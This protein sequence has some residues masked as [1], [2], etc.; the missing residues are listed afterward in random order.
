MLI[1]WLGEIITIKTWLWEGFLFLQP[2][3][4]PTENKESIISRLKLVNN[5]QIQNEIATFE[6]DLM[7][8]SCISL[9]KGQ[10]KKMKN[11]LVLKS[12]TRS[13][14]RNVVNHPV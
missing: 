5:L 8:T 2:P 14:V 6:S 7:W 13:S 9:I 3:G 10:K 12:S 11:Q 1:I 4:K